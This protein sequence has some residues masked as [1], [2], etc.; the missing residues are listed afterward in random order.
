MS[1][2][3]KL[4]PDGSNTIPEEYLPREFE[5]GKNY[6]QRLSPLE[7]RRL[8]KR[9][10]IRYRPEYAIIA[11]EVL[12]SGKGAPSKSHVSAALQC[13]KYCIKSWEVKYPEFKRA[14]EE[15]FTIGKAIWLTKLG[16]Y[17]FRPAGLVNNSLIKLLSNVVYD[18]EER[19]GVHLQLERKVASNDIESSISEKEAV[20]LYIDMINEDKV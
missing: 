9:G 2:L 13:S 18:I 3:E 12:T 1:L 11:F 5:S 19:S 15:G 14:M 4:L 16:E 10:T 8:E 20:N 7:S 6:H 17:A